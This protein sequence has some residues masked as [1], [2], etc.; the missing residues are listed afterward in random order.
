MGLI[1]TI[2][3]PHLDVFLDPRLGE[4][5]RHVVGPIGQRRLLPRQSGQFALQEI[6]ERLTQ[7][8]DVCAVAVDE[9][10]RHVQNPI[11][12][13]LKAHALLKR[14]RQHAS[15]GRIQIAPDAATP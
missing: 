6:A 1:A 4:H 3:P 15:A 9:I 7:R 14:P 12:I 2:R 8:V 11:D 10:H 5:G 13:A